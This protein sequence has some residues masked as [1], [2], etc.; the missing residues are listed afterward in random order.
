MKIEIFQQGENNKDYY[1]IKQEYINRIEKYCNFSIIDT[2]PIKDDKSFF[3]QIT[4]YGMEVPSEV[5]SKKLDSILTCGYSKIIFFLI[6]R[7]GINRNSAQNIN[8]D[9]S[10]NLS[11][12][13]STFD[14]KLVLLLEQI[15]RCFKINNG[16]IYHK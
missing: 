3:I 16:E 6:P 11:C 1:H 4:N 2:Y 7:D 14:M 15:Y 8:F 13:K 12:I 5:F 10:L 9:Y